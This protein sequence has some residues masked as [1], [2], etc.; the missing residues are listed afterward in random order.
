[1]N[2]MER[3]TGRHSGGSI[4]SGA[5]RRTLVRPLSMLVAGRAEDTVQE[6]SR[7][8]S[9]NREYQVS[10]R[11]ITN[12]HADPLYSI[13]TQPDALIFV[14]SGDW[15]DE[16]QSLAE[17]PAAARPPSLIIGLE[18]NPEAMRL[19]MRA[20][21]REFLKWPDQME[22][23][24]TALA[25][26]AG[27]C[28]QDAKLQRASVTTVINAKGGSGATF[29][30]SSLA[31]VLAVKDGKQAA[32]LDLD[33]QF[34]GL[35]SYFDLHMKHGLLEVLE[36]VPEMDDVALGG[37]MTHHDSG[38]DLLG[39]RG[40]SVG[41]SEE[42]E[43]ERFSSLLELL[44][45]SYERL[46]I[47]APRHLDHMTIQALESSDK[48]LVV[49]QQNLA[50]LKDAIRMLAILR[51]ELL[52]PKERLIVVINRYDSRSDIR[53]EDIKSTLCV[54]TV[55]TVANAFNVVTE[56]L[57]TGIPLYDSARKSKVARSIV[58]LAAAIE[59]HT[60]DPGSGILGHALAGLRKMMDKKKDGEQA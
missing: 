28:M 3:E 53:L 35:E 55:M 22:E 2:M 21:A 50:S 4:E 54:N 6:I 8:L 14:L 29:V 46:V 43:T 58:T 10:S 51:N 37:Y 9:R 38:L 27:E 47:D 59:G 32:L 60:A 18:E 40:A 5:R 41:L 39:T 20:G 56:S 15:R 11:S 12:G 33:L 36:A 57:N 31:H 23:M 13:D 48:V 7:Q 24:N 49:L 1:M 44:S 17:R 34:A 45:L 26:I 16:L 19:A 30:A 42:I 52:I 25:L